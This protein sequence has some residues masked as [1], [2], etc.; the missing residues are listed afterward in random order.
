M[1]ESID[2][3]AEKGMAGTRQV[4]PV[5][6]GVTQVSVSISLKHAT[7][8]DDSSKST[9]TPDYNEC[10]AE[11]DVELLPRTVSALEYAEIQKV[12]SNPVLPSTLEAMPLPSRQ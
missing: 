6:A 11:I 9:P 8:V 4:F 12:L 7:N 10:L 3:S 2:K 5:V 1:S